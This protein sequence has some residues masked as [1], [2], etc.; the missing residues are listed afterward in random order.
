MVLNQGTIILDAGYVGSAWGAD[1]R[2]AEK[3]RPFR[4]CR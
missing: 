3:T 2:S 1:G 4:S